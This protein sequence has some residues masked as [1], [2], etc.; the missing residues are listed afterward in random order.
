MMMTCRLL[1]ALLVLALCCCPSVCVM[2]SEVNDAPRTDPAVPKASRLQE[3]G[4]KEEISG[5]KEK[6]P[7]IIDEEIVA[8]DGRDNRKDLPTGGSSNNQG[9]S[10]VSGQSQLQ[11]P[12]VLLQLPTAPTVAS[13]AQSGPI[14]PEKEEKK[15]TA[16]KTT[17]T[18]T[19]K[20]PTT[21]TKTTTTTAA[22]EAT[23]DAA[24]SAEVPTTTT[25]RTPSRLREVDGSL[26]SSAWVCALLLLPFV[27]V[28]RLFVL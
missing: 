24:N 27:T 9:A 2:A 20:A 11:S 6:D 8:S 26:S 13:G 22:P 19:T 28:R 10:G 5:R 14:V 21:T 7:F 15:T 18:T 16:S 23:S 12:G 17:T 4:K 25:T 1:C 3:P